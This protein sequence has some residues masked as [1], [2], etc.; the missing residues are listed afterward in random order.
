MSRTDYPEFS[1]AWLANA[2][3]L[4]QPDTAVHAG[5]GQTNSLGVLRLETSHG[6]FAVK[7]FED[8]PRQTA[9][10]IETAAY[11]AGFPMPKPFWTIDGE[12]YAV[13]LYAGRPIWVR[14]YSW[15]DG[16]AYDWGIVDAKLS[17][18]IGR[19]LSELHGLPVPR[20]VLQD[21]PWQPLGQPGWERLSVQA[22][23]KG[24]AWS[25]NLREKLPELVGWED[26][27]LACTADDEPVV[28][29]QRDLHPPNVMRCADG[30]H[31]VLDWDAA[32]PVNAREEV[33]NFALVWASTPEPALA[34]EAV[35][36][37][38]S[39]YRAA[40]GTF[41]SRGILDLTHQVRSLLWWLAFNVRRD[42][43]EHPGPDP[44]LTSALLSSV[45]D[46]S[47]ERLRQTAVL[48]EPE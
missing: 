36:A 43:S 45:S 17:Y 39:G 12:P 42:V 21:D 40:G 35:R 4:G 24:V 10:L 8:Q 9:L 3:G 15:V 47:L 37:F 48:F 23:A 44:D 5:R 28:P 11:K 30:R 25:R 29:S 41:V 7:R 34:Q 33:A 46:L 26:H 14:V 22:E 13:C 18:R 16:S 2:F 31:A 32:G 20:E 27:V 19:L 6:V 38:I 1:I